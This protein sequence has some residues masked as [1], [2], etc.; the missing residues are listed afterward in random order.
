MKFFSTLTQHQVTLALS[1]YIGV[2]LNSVCLVRNGVAGG[3]LPAISALLSAVA[4][5]AFCYLLLGFLVYSANISIKRF[6]ASPCLRQQ[7]HVIT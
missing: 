4:L 2:I 5:F 6:R 7:P 1:L 3:W